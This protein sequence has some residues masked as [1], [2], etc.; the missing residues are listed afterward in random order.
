ML[1]P[2]EPGERPAELEHLR[3]AVDVD[4]AGGLGSDSQVVDGRQV[5]DLRH[6]REGVGRGPADAQVR[7]G[8]VALGEPDPP[9]HLGMAGLHRAQ[10]LLRRRHVPG[11]HQAHRPHSLATREQAGKQG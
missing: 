11:L 3:R 10:P 1:Q 9:A 7:R 2:V 5:P 8:D 4:P 6:V